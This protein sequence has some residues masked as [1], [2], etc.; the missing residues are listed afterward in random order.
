MSP[1]KHALPGGLHSSKISK[2]KSGNPA[3]LNCP[4]EGLP[5]G[6]PPGQNKYSTGPKVGPRG[7]MARRAQREF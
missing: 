7:G 6:N 5:T 4:I 2:K 1:R 3:K